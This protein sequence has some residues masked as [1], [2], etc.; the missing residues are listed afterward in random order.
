MKRCSK[1]GEEKMLDMFPRH[2]SRPDGRN[3]WCRECF[4]KHRAKDAT[5]WGA[6]QEKRKEEDTLLVLG[7]KQ[8]SKCKEI[9]DVSEFF[10]LKKANCGYR[11]SC[12]KCCGDISE[13]QK[14]KQNARKKERYANDSEYRKRINESNN[15]SPHR[16]SRKRKETA[17]K[18]R[19]VN[20]FEQALKSSVASAK[21]YGYMPCNATAGELKATF[22]GKCDICGVPELECTRRLAMDHDHG[23][24]GDFRGWLC[25]K[26]NVALGLFNDNEGL[27][28]DALHYLMNSNRKVF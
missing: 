18:Y 8:C 19:E 9:K 24:D 14:R 6:L 20:R 21:R 12:K 10:E 16:H 4:G 17:K 26:C 27:L 13:E 22:T 7:K 23:N 2:V 28:I 15:K 3:G 5:S 1:C 11:S 25:D